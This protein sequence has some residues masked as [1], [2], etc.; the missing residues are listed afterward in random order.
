MWSDIV[1]VGRRSLSVVVVGRRVVVALLCRCRS[2]RGRWSSSLVV[3][4]SSVVAS[5]S[6]VT[7]SSVIASLLSGVVSLSSLVAVGG[8]CC[9]CCRRCRRW[10]VVGRR[11]Q[12][13]S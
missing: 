5:S 10:S 12:L 13:W 7:S 2:S 3:A 8:R 6:V 4:W 9:R 11:G 1:V